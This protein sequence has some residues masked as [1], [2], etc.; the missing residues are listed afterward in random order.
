M[1]D[2]EGPIEG[3]D[4]QVQAPLIRFLDE[5]TSPPRSWWFKFNRPPAH[6]W[7]KYGVSVRA[8]GIHQTCTSHATTTMIEAVRRREGDGSTTLSPSFIHTCIGGVSPKQGLDPLRLA[9]NVGTGRKAPAYNGPQPWPA[10]A[11]AIDAGALV[12]ALVEVR[13]D[14]DAK[15]ALARSPVVASMQIG[16]EFQSLRD[17]RYSP[18]G[19]TPGDHIICIVAALQDGWLIQNSYGVD[20]GDG[21]FAE[22]AF[23][24]GGLLRPGFSAIALA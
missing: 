15:I 12:P 4:R 14:A 17:R 19:S 1:T 20:W 24:V 21:G 2:P 11:C 13:G 22:V 8:Q 5:Q 16:A 3:P 23:G 9:R 18:N 7:S 10:D 6:D